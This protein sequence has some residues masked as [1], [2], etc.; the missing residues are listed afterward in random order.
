MAKLMTA[1][2]RANAGLVSAAWLEA[3]DNAST[4]LHVK[5]KLIPGTGLVP[6]CP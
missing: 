3:L 1:Q 2:P 4:E 5:A 6:S